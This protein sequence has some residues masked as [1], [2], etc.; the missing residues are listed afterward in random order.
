M[1][2]KDPQI[3]DVFERTYNDA[4]PDIDYIVGKDKKGLIILTNGYQ[5]LVILR[6]VTAS[7]YKTSGP[8]IEV[9]LE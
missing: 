3:G 4:E 5:G 7:Y 1:S 6:G 8:W 9:K 2:L